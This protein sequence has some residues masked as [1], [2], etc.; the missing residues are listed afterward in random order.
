M[1][2]KDKTGNLHLTKTPYRKN[3]PIPIETN[4]KNTSKNTNKLTTAYIPSNLKQ[5]I[6]SISNV[7]LKNND[8]ITSPYIATSYH[9]NSLSTSSTASPIIAAIINNHTTA[10]NNKPNEIVID[11]DNTQRNTVHNQN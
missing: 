10:A 11:A 2:N 4:L 7:V 8:S 5:S 6:K 3:I 9:I 1:N